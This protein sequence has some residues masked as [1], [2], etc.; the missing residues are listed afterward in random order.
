MGGYLSASK[1]L[2]SKD[3]AGAAKRDC[4]NVEKRG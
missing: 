2:N 4:G 1:T 3:D